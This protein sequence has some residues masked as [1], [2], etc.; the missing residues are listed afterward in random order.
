MLRFL[1]GGRKEDP[2]E[3]E[4]MRQSFVRVMGE[5]NELIDGLEPKPAVTIDPASGH[6]TLRL[7]KQLPDEALGLPA[8]EEVAATS[9]PQAK[10]K[11]AEPEKAAAEKAPEAAAKAEDK[12]A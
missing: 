2:V 7:P 6:V 4:T 11:A 5:L 12:A 10:D 3:I 8:P 9:A 1:F